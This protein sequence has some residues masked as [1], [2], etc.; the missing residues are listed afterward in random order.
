MN[1]R[2]LLAAACFVAALPA[3]SGCASYGNMS[4]S[5]QRRMTGQVVGGV[6]GAALGS[7]IGGG[8]GKALAIGAGAVVGGILGGEVANR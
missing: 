8:T 1:T 4:E 7:L 6:T 5:D 3:L 2:T